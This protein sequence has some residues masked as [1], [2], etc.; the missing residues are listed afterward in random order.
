MNRVNIFIGVV[1]AL[2]L[3]FL[4]NG[5]AQNKSPEN[6]TGVTSNSA[7][8]VAS[9]ALPEVVV[10]ASRGLRRPDTIVLSKR[11]SGVAHD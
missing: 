2:A 11:D 10:T 7:G 3:T 6:L 9:D 1:T 8:S 4:L 5:C